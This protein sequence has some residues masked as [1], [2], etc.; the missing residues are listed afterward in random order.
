MGAFGRLCRSVLVVSSLSLGV[1]PALPE[2]LEGEHLPATRPG[3]VLTA[4]GQ[5]E[6]FR[7]KARVLR[8]ITVLCEG[9][10]KWDQSEG[11]NTG[12]TGD[13]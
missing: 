3:R 6:R 5:A 9:N 4:A 13:T 7:G 12:S 11:T 1:T 10:L 2:I 8:C